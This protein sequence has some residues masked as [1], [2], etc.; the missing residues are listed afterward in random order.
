[1]KKIIYIII[2]TILISCSTSENLELKSN[3]TISDTFNESEINDLQIIFDFFNGEICDS[4]KLNNESLNECYEKYCYEIREQRK[5]GFNF[6]SKI[7]FEKQLEMYKR[8][9]QSTF[10]EIW[11]FQN[12][13]DIN[14]LDNFKY[15]EYSYLGKYKV[16]LKKYG[17]ENKAIHN[18][19]E[20]I[21]FEGGINP[22]T[23]GGL[24]MYYEYFDIS[25]IR[26]KL[27]IAIQYLTFNDQL[28]RKEKY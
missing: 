9:D 28:E 4:K 7:D 21:E 14:S 2:S 20:G 22:N 17:E 8:I 10:K 23:L 12:R 16:F 5:I 19:Y 27:V 3:K 11:Y 26:T 18:F 13:T 24:D 1:M 6:N 25:D 15:L